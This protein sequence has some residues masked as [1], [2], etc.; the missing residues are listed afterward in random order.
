MIFPHHLSIS[1]YMQ[2][3]TEIAREAILSYFFQNNLTCEQ[4]GYCLAGKGKLCA[5]DSPG[6][7]L[8]TCCSQHGDFCL[9]QHA[10][11][12]SSRAIEASVQRPSVKLCWPL[13]RSIYTFVYTSAILQV[14]VVGSVGERR[15]GWF[16][17]ARR[18]S[19]G[20]DGTPSARFSPYGSN[21]RTGVVQNPLLNC[22]CSLPRFFFPI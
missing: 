5:R 6:A 8:C 3:W 14:P 9:C 15:Q 17:S 4:R 10:L 11:S 7:L 19:A 18:S 13:S 12:Y 22:S 20:L 16:L 21:S 1:Q 2:V